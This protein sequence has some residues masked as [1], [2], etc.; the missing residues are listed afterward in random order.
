ML[1]LQSDGHACLRFLRT[2]KAT[3]QL[4]SPSL[5]WAQKAGRFAGFVVGVIVF[6]NQPEAVN[7]LDHIMY[8]NILGS[9]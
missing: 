7:I 1:L 5:P 3:F 9:I 6:L 8:T 2:S 4:G